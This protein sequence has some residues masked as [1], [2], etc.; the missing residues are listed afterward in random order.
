MYGK[1]MIS[2]E[3]GTGTSYINIHNETGLV[4]PPSNPLAFREAMRTLWDN[5]VRAAQMGMKAEARYRQLFTAEDMGR[6]WTA[7]YQELLEEKS[8]SYA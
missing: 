8:L 5:P 6:K 4:V 7:L 3:I 2:S 1:P